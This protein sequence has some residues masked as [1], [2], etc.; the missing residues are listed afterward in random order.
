MKIP[1]ILVEDGYWNS[2]KAKVFIK[3]K[4]LQEQAKAYLIKIDC[5]F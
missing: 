1:I 2:K 3:A 5:Y 4:I